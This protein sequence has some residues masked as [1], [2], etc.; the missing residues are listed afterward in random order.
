MGKHFEVG[1][2]YFGRFL[3]DWDSIQTIKVLSRTQKTVKVGR[4]GEPKT[5][6]VF[7]DFGG[8][9]AIRPNGNHSMCMVIS[10]DDQVAA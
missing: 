7:A 1:A 9:E 6:R 10:A 3:S 5:F 8:N 4:Y 2:S